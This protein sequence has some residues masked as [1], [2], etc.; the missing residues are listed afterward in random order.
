MSE[1]GQK[2]SRKAKVHSLGPIRQR[3]KHETAT[4]SSVQTVDGWGQELGL[5][6][7]LPTGDRTDHFSSGNFEGLLAL[8]EVGL[9][10]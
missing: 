6:R 3:I 5:S 8:F 9:E 10:L 4:V 7:A 1:V 2:Y